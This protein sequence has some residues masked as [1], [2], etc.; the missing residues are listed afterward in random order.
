MPGQPDSVSSPW[1][2]F[3]RFSI[4]GLIV[5]VLVIGAGLG[6]IVREADVQR[7]AVLAIT[8]AGGSICY[9]W[10]WSNGESIPRGKP[11]AP[12]WLVELIGVDYFGHVTYVE[13]FD[14]PDAT[15][16]HVGRLAPQM[17]FSASP[18][19]TDAGLAH[20]RGPTNLSGLWL[21]STRVTDAGLVHLKG[22]TNLS[23]LSLDGAH[24]TDA[25]LA[26]LGGLTKLSDLRLIGTRVTDTGLVHLKGLTNLSVLSLD[27][28][29]VTGAGL[30]HLGGLT[31]LSELLLDGTQ[32]T[33][34]GLAHLRGLTKL[35]FLRLIST[36]VTDAG[37]KELKLAL[38]GLTIYH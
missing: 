29:Q 33:D 21:I 25:G 11:L 2:R 6:W 32:V 27:G 23:F 38:P 17:F 1:R 36:R 24:V 5:L 7:D 35:S 10:E 31:K 8:A 3:L 15:L 9:D 19:V 18:T 34:A 12:Q 20:L 13:V 16:A 22:L 28:A 26:H 14:V 4:R 37:I 30:A